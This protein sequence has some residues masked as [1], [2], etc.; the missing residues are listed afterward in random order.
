MSSPLTLEL[1]FAQ[2][3]NEAVLRLLDYHQLRR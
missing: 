1:L 2:S 3:D